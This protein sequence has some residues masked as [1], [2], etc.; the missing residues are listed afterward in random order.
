MMEYDEVIFEAKEFFVKSS[1]RNRCEVV[2]P[3]GKQILSIQIKKGKNKKRL[4]QD[5]EITFD[6]RWNHIHWY[7]LM[8]NYRSSPYFEFYE[9]I[10]EPYFTKEYSSLFEFNIELFELV[11]KLLSLNIKHSLTKEF[12]KEVAE[13]TED[14]RSYFMPNKAFETEEFKEYIQV[15]SSK[16]GFFPNLSILDLL[17]C[18]GPN[19]INFLK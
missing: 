1:Y 2:G 17:F 16:V 19:A 12:H 4:Y 18:E 5:V 13:D 10:L 14:C 15:F 7:A 8:S 3:N 11:N 6:H 9:D